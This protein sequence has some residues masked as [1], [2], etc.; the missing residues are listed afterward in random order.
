LEISLAGGRESG[1]L[2]GSLAAGPFDQDIPMSKATP[3]Y[4]VLLFVLIPYYQSQDELL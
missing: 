1:L 2:A 3:E 4:Q